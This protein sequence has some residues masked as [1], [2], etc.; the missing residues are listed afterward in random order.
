MQAERPL[1]KRML[2]F[3]LT[4]LL[5]VMLIAVFYVAVVMGQPQKSSKAD[6][7]APT[8]QALPAPLHEAVRITDAADFQLLA[9]AFP[10]PIL[11]PSSSHALVLIEG[12]CRDTAFENGVA[13]IVTLTYQ[14]E[15]QSLLTISSIYPARAYALLQKEG[16]SFSTQA[17]HRL[18][19]IS[20]VRMESSSAIRLHAQGAEALYAFA[21][22]K[23]SS[24][25]LEQW[26]S[27]L[28]L[29]VGN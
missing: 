8:A 4:A 3:I 25:V 21:A 6:K 28:M 26:T 16:Y 29:Y 14:T 11:R 9:A 23:V 7:S 5:S 15:D 22:P 10:A 17:R 13:R 12:L 20:A 24:D 18:A 1:W 2:R 27:S 19:G